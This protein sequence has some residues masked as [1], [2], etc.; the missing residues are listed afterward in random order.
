MNRDHPNYNIVEIG[1][2]AEKS[3]GDLGRLTVTQ[4]LGKDHQ[5]KDGEKKPQDVK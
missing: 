4:T 5:T 2:N 3:H 1:Q